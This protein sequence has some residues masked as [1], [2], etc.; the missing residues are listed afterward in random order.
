MTPR[1]YRFVFLLILIAALSGAP[2]GPSVALKSPLDGTWAGCSFQNVSFRITD[3]EGIDPNSIRV[4]IAGVLYSMPDPVFL[5]WDGDSILRF[6]PMAPFPNGGTVNID[7][8]E[9]RDLGGTSMP[10]PLSWSFN[11]DFD[12]PFCV[13]ETREPIPDTTVITV[14]PT[15]RIEVKDTTSGIPPSGLCL[16]FDSRNYSC[17]GDRNSGYCLDVSTEHI[18]YDGDFFTIVTAGL[19][20]AFQN[21]DSVTVRLRK[22]IDYVPQGADVCGPNWIDTLNPALEWSFRV[23]IT[24][25][26][27]TLLFPNDGDTIACDTLII[28]LEDF[29]PINVASCRLRLGPGLATVGTSP[30][31]TAFGD[32]VVYSGTGTAEFYPEGQISVYV[33]SV[34]D[35]VG[36]SS[37]YIGGEH[38]EWRFV[39]DKTPPSACS[40]S[41]SAGGLSADDS[42]TISLALTDSISGIDPTSIVFTIDGTPFPFTSP[43]VTW[44]GSV[45]RFLPSLVGMAWDDGDSVYV[46]VVASDK[47]RADRCGPNTMPAFCWNFLIDQGGPIVHILAPPMNTIT[48]CSLQQVRIRI[49]DYSGVDISTLQLSVNGAIFTG[50]DH[51]VYSHDTLTFTPTVPFIDGDTVDVVVLAVRDSTGNDIAAPVSSRFIIDRRPPSITSIV[52]PP[53]STIAHGTE[54]IFHIVDAIAGVRSTDFSASVNGAAFPWPTGFIWDGANLRF[55]CSIAEPFDDGDTIEFCLQFSDIVAP[56]FCGPNGSDTCFVLYYDASGPS[57]ELIYPPDRSITACADG[58][59]VILPSSDLPID[60][61]TLRLR[62]DGALYDTS[63]GEVSLRGDTI[64]FVP[65]TPFPHRDTVEIALLALDDI[66]GNGLV[67]MPLEWTVFIDIMPPEISSISP[68]AG[69]FPAGPMVVSAALRDFPSG[70]DEG[71]IVVTAD[72]IAY[73]FGDP[74]LEWDGVRLYFDFETAGV[75]VSEGEPVIFCIG[76][77]ADNVDSGLCGPNIGLADTCWEYLFDREGPAARLLSPAVGAISS[78]EEIAFVFEITDHSGIDGSSIVVIFDGGDYTIDDPALDWTPPFCTFTPFGDFGHADTVSATLAEVSDIF[79]NPLDSADAI[80]AFYIIDIEPPVVESPDPP[81]LS[82]VSDPSQIISLRASDSPAGINLDS[83]VLQVEET[84]YPM[85]SDGLEWLGDRLVFD[86]TEAGISFA[87]GDTVEVCLNS[88]TDAPDTC[89]PNEISEPFCWRFFIDLAGP[90]ARIKRPLPDSWVAC[91]H[92]EQAILATVKDNDGVVPSSIRLRVDGEEFDI[93]S[94]AMSFSDSMLTFVPESPWLDGQTVSAELFAAEDSTGN[95]LVNPLSWQFYIDRQPPRCS[96]PYPPDGSTIPPPDSISLRISDGGSGVAESALTLSVNGTPFTLASGLHWDGEFVSLTSAVAL[97]G[98]SGVVELCLD[99]PLDRPDYCDPNIGERF[100]WSVEIDDG[101]P[102]ARPIAP[103]NGDFVACVPGSQSILIYLHD[104]FGILLDSIVLNIDGELVEF[105]D[106][107]LS[108]TDSLL[109]YTPPIPWMDGDTISVQL[110]SAPD[111]FGNPVSP[112]SYVFYIDRSSPELFSVAPTPGATI[113]P[114]AT[115]IR[116]GLHDRLSGIDPSSIIFRIDG[117]DYPFG[118][119]LGPI[120]SPSESTAVMSLARVPHSGGRIEVCI[121]A[122]DRPDLC[123]PNRF[124]DCFDYMV[125]DDGPTLLLE[126]PALYSCSSCSLQGFRALLNDESMIDDTTIAFRVDGE[127]FTSASSEVVFAAIDRRVYF[128]PSSPWTDGSVV[129]IDSFYVADILHNWG[130]DLLDLEFYIDLKP[131]TITPLSPIPGG[132]VSRPSPRIQFIVAD[133]GCAGVNPASIRF[134]VDGRIFSPESLGVHYSPD[135]IRFEAGEAGMV[136]EDGDTVE[137]CVIG[138]SDRALYCGQNFIPLPI[139]WSFTIN[140]S[141]PTAEIV[142]PASGQWV[143]CDSTDQRIKI[144]L[145]DPDGLNLNSISLIVEGTE[146]TIDSIGLSYST[147][148][149]ELQFT[150]SIPWLDGDTVRVILNSAEDSYGNG[151]SAPLNF[152]FY[153]DRTPPETTFV[154]PTVGIAIH[155]GLAYIE[156][157]IEDRGAGIVDRSVSIALDGIWHSPGEPGIDWVGSRLIYDGSLRVPPDTIFAGDTVLICVMADDSTTL[158]GP[159]TMIRCWNY[160]TTSNGPYAEPRFPANGAIT[161][162]ADTGVHIFVFD[163]DG[164]NIVPPSFVTIIDD[165]FVIRGTAYPYV[166]YS[167]SDTTLYIDVGPHTHGD[168]VHVVIDSVRDIYHA[169]LTSPFA[170]WFV[171]DIEGPEILSGWPARDEVIPPGNPDLGFVCSDFPAGIDRSRG[172]ISLFGL[173]YPIEGGALWRGDTLL[174]PGDSYSRDTVLSV[175]DSI[176][177]GIT[178][179]DRAE[180]CGANISVTEWCFSVNITAPTAAILTPED[181]AI[182]S[183]DGGAIRILILDDDGLRYDSCGV[184]IDGIRRTTADP[185]LTFIGDTLFYNNPGEFDHGNTVRFWPFAKDIY[186][187]PLQTADTFTFVVDNRAPS[188]HNQIP[189]PDFQALDWQQLIGLILT[190]EIAGVEESSLILRATTPRW[191]RDLYID[192]NGVSW[193]DSILTFDPR[194]F[195]GGSAWEPALDDELIYWHELDTVQILVFAEDKACCCGANDTVF[196]W[197]FSVLDDDTVPPAFSG[198]LPTG[199][200]DGFTEFVTAVIVDPS[201]IYDDYTDIGGQGVFLIWDSDGDLSDG[202][203]S[204]VQM[205]PLAGDTFISIAPIGPFFAGDS[206]ILCISAYDNDFDFQRILDRRRGISDTI[207][208]ELFIGQGPVASMIYP[209]EGVY[210]SCDSGLVIILLHDGQGVNPASIR[211]LVDGESFVIGPNLSFSNDT[212]VFAPIRR[213]AD[214]DRV[215]VRLTAAE[216]SLGYGLDSIYEWHYHIDL[217]PPDIEAVGFSPLLSQSVTAEILWRISDNGAGVFDSSIAIL[218]GDARFDVWHPLIDWDGELLTFDPESLGFSLEDS[219][220]ICISACDLSEIC[221]RNCHDPV[222]IT[223]R[224][225]KTTPCEVWPIPFTPNSDG[226]NDVVWFEFPGMEFEPATIEI[227]SLEGKKVFAEDFHPASPQTSIRWD[228]VSSSGRRATPGTYIYLIIKENEILCKGTLVLVR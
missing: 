193:V 195:N 98:L 59:I 4:R 81:N 110:I 199:L 148:S 201:G 40:P 3:I 190:D 153:I 139:C 106:G 225:S 154:F 214:G 123:G 172:I 30:Y 44:D 136:W 13:A 216:D 43:A 104:D 65:S 151:L 134:T 88:L 209:F 130:E 35:S 77:L 34:R 53:G 133:S 107:S 18:N 121:Q 93:A 55:D 23:D 138:A 192:T 213:F 210:S 189:P 103:R 144:F 174:L 143:A 152:E 100:C 82:T 15:I 24:G 108:F 167:W 124:I 212:L 66:L 9:V 85:P 90:V 200:L 1:F 159:N 49:Y 173:D 227:Y 206:P 73:P 219:T 191:S 141:G 114:S 205:E 156:V 161:S 22:A 186:G 50:L 80:F 168:T 120:W 20:V 146:F 47:V 202:G 162:C 101:N 109:R 112:I 194:L 220:E 16:C 41:P 137:V 215:T 97:S 226:A 158:C 184:Y 63:D 26:R 176:C 155:P 224:R 175:G 147:I 6:T 126:S 2:P 48:A 29:S 183:C 52:P 19:G 42:P 166:F 180:Y 116:A 113:S 122:D 96:E 28:K 56:E 188:G 74:A 83:V 58:E 94:P 10:T 181:G 31:L 21:E 170:L 78:C 95:P 79:G 118:S 7:F 196:E 60:F 169:P 128:V 61:S 182:T 51:S 197:S 165:T 5:Y 131:P 218:I 67:G 99:A 68:P 69:E 102:S 17:P 125:D 87:D 27:S 39:V 207:R 145:A 84:E 71:S 163:S 185:H 178:L 117:T 119:P 223:V 46:C 228:G 150:P 25:P 105:S 222:C 157:G 37:T 72:G 132:F 217:S 57:A 177:L 140:T 208:P 33:N 149:S 64:V 86:P 164:D 75:S 187:T 142:T 11:I 54:L 221:G 62:I 127:L 32:T 70:V 12:K 8:L 115:V 89:H 211:L 198:I 45:A 92:P 38:M 76:A 204:I 36:N 129:R 135:T 171:I 160:I 179:F 203:E 14:R 91:A 111:S